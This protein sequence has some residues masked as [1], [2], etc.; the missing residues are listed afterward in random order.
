MTTT[1]PAVRTVAKGVGLN[2]GLLTASVN[3][4]SAVN[5]KAGSSNVMICQHE[6]EAMK[7][8]SPKMC[9]KCGEVDQTSLG[10]A[11][12]V[13]GGLVVLT[14]DDLIAAKAPTEET[15]KRAAITVHPRN[16]VDLGTQAGEKAYFLHPSAGHE[17]AYATLSALVDA[18]PE[19]AFCA[20][21]TP[22]SEQALFQ[23]RTVD[24]TLLMQERAIAT[25]R[26]APK[27]E[28]KAVDDLVA[29]AER[30]LKKQVTKFDP[31]H[32]STTE[33]LDALIAGRPIISVGADE[34]TTSAAQAVEELRTAMKAELASQRAARKPKAAAKPRTV[35]E[36]AA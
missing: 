4:T 8:R 21:W 29:L 25:L 28:A 2:L 30:L 1:A 35:K 20:R 19:L 24:G 10:R 11:R 27:V 7:V 6:H 9:P 18:H 13:D 5:S 17:A 31:T 32:T 26:E 3:M 14:E 16:Q 33:I 12:Q 34:T 22:R 36:K 23:L 15:K